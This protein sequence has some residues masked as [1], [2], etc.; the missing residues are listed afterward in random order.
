MNFGAGARAEVV[1]LVGEVV[2][3]YRGEG[4]QTD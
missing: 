3:A 4:S 1:G 2:L